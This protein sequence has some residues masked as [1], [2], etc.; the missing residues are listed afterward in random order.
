MVPLRTKYKMSSVVKTTRYIKACSDM[1]G[2]LNG[3]IQESQL[4]TS[5][6]ISVALMPIVCLDDRR[7]SDKMVGQCNIKQNYKFQNGV[8]GI[9]LNWSPK[10]L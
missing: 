8:G 9:S 1:W 6:L 5:N 4:F 3:T 2:K 10:I 7:E